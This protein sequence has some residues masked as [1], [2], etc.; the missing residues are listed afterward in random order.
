MNFKREHVCCSPKL[1]SNIAE[2]AEIEEAIA[3]VAWNGQFRLE[4]DDKRYE[5]QTGYNKALAIQLHKRGWMMQPRLCENPRLI[6][7]AS[8]NGVF[9]EV[10]FGNSSTLYRDY[11][12][13]HYGLLNGLLSLAVLIVPTNPLQFFPTRP[14]SVSNMAEYDLAYR[15]F[16]LLQIPVPILLI[17]LLPEN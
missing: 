14:K 12:K 15:S 11:Y 3:N 10:Q 1:L 17:G 5:H 16:K 8:K 6:G 2:I 7:D 13:F 9:V 4:A